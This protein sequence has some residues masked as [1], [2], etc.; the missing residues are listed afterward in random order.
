MTEKFIFE[1]LFHWKYIIELKKSTK[2]VTES[3]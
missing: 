3:L 1:Y 2:R